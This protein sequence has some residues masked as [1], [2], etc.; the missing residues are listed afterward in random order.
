MP[1]QAILVHRF[2]G[3]EVLELQQLPMPEAMPGQAVV[4]IDYAG[5]NFVDLYQREG[6]YP[7]ISL[8]WRLGL[9]GAGEIVDV[10]PG[11]EFQLGDRVAFTTGVQGAYA[12][13]LAVPLEHLVRVPDAL[14]LRDAAAALEHGLTAAMLL[15]DVAR[16]PA[17][18]PVLV[19][20]A[21]GGVGGWLVQWLIARGHP[22]FGTVSNAAKADWLRGLGAAPLLADSDWVSAA[23]GVAVVF[24]S[25]G[26]STFAGSLDVL[27][28]GGHLVL[29]GAASGQPEPV[30]VLALQ[31]KSLTLTRPVLP[32]FLPDAAKRRARAATVFDALLSGAVQL[33]IHAEFPLADAASAHELL[34]SRAT[35]GKLLLKP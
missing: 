29:F 8:P 21:A 1:A 3:S 19:H 12:S 32:H 22:V 5:I 27:R 24:D 17:R 16:L 10:T 28:M 15:D 2:G 9:E 7:N 34:A 31:K 14:S 6:R 13:H 30:D 35:Q 23:R 25:V 26:R 11:A 4:R 33:R 20:A 18:E